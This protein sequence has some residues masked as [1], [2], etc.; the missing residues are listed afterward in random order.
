MT[1]AKCAVSQC[2][3]KLQKL[4]QTYSSNKCA[5]FAGVVVLEINYLTWE[6]GYLPHPNTKP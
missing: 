6:V 4:V 3:V 2:F 1:K 5:G